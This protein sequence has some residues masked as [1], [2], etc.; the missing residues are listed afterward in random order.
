MTDIEEYQRYL[1][2]L[3]ILGKSQPF[4]VQC[5]V[6]NS[7]PITL[8]EIDETLLKDIETIEIPGFIQ[9]FQRK[10]F[11]KKRFKRLVIHN[12]PDRN[13]ELDEI[14]EGFFGKELQIYFEH[15]ERVISLRETF[16]N[17][18]ELRT[19]TFENLNISTV[20]DLSSCFNACIS[21]QKIEFIGID[22]IA[23]QQSN[24]VETL[25]DTFKNCQSLRDYNFLYL[26]D[27]S[28]VKDLQGTF[29]HNERLVEIH[30]NRLDLSSVEKMQGTFIQC[31]HL[32]KIVDDSNIKINLPKLR[33][34]TKTFYYCSF[35]EHLDMRMFNIP[36][37][38]FMYETFRNSY[39]LDA[40]FDGVSLPKLKN[41]N[42]CFAYIEQL[43][44][45]DIQITQSKDSPPICLDYICNKC[46]SLG[47]VRIQKEITVSSMINSFSNT[48]FI[49]LDLQ[50]VTIMKNNAKDDKFS[51][52]LKSSCVRTLISPKFN[53]S[54]SL[55]IQ[56]FLDSILKYAKDENIQ[57]LRILDNSHK[58]KKSQI[59]YSC[60]NGY[61]Q[62]KLYG[63]TWQTG[64][65]TLDKKL[66]TPISMWRI[67]VDDTPK[68]S[69]K[70]FKLKLYVHN[71][72]KSEFEKM[73]DLYE[74]WENYLDIEVYSDR[75]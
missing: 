15:P 63:E 67:D 73:L 48:Q 51:N 25:Q 56:S 2:K 70:Y 16:N 58:A 31:T 10:C 55:S 7:E 57:M 30:L 59:G 42:G 35:L 45:L 14:F 52:M 74:G 19:I 49:T 39:I 65:E 38:E 53:N 24:R 44:N 54:D 43:R 71:K 12:K 69:G 1:A 28:K 26:M 36:N 61:N 4:K 8:V 5:D 72:N 33:D 17:S 68:S 50:N 22:Q 21:L 27:L 6:E 9:K 37:V 64:E 62:E 11:N 3:K 32:E 75:Q 66:N 34:M 29:I 18:Y 47:K 41:L 60:E 13:L 20:K 23:Y 40:T 46:P